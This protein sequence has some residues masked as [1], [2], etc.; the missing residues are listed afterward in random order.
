M[1]VPEPG[2]DYTD[3]VHVTND[4]SSVH[5]TFQSLLR[6]R[7]LVSPAYSSPTIEENI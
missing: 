6:Q 4:S 2:P 3:T 1:A 7:F 5:N